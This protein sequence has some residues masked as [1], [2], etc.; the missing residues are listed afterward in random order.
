MGLKAEST[1]GPVEV[2]ARPEGGG[3][4]A[5]GKATWRNK[6]QTPLAIAAET[7]SPAARDISGDDHGV[8]R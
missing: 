8:K 6:E 7:D 5:A 2:V 1:K 3:G 4:E